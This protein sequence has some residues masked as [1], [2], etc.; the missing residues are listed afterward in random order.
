[1][2]GVDRDKLVLDNMGLVGMVVNKHKHRIYYHPSIDTEDLKSV[3]TIGLIK[4]SQGFD[5]NYGT[6][7]STYAVTVIE[8]EI[9]KYLRDDLDL[10]RFTRQSKIDSSKIVEAGLIDA[11]PEII[12][13]KL[14]MSIGD[15]QNALDYYHYRLVG[16]TDVVVYDDEG[17]PVTVG[18]FIGYEPDFDSNLEVDLFLSRLD[19]RTR[20]IVEL[21]MQGLNQTEIGE[22]VG[23]SQ[24]QI[25]RDLANLREMIEKGEIG[26]K[27][28]ENKP[29]FHLA[30]QLAEETE[31]KPADIQRKTRV[32]YSTALKYIKQYRKEHKKTST[33]PTT[34]GYVTMTFQLTVKDA[35]T[36]L[37][38]ILNAMETLGFK[39]IDMTIQSQQGA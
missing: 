12:A 29:N 11:E 8:G 4:A 10:I 13:K 16:S 23:V 32:S 17:P 38:K 25:S 27:E 7:F 33:K 19:D 36:Q 14:E 21:R 20:K 37:E 2:K 26:V 6:Q 24:V 30:K 28:M 34:D 22:I 9:K 15:V 31:L 39:Q 3:G 5:P 1:M 18:D 35:T